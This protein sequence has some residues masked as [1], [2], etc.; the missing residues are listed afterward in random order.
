MNFLNEL[1]SLS[2]SLLLALVLS[3]GV[4]FAYAQFGPDPGTVAPN[5]NVPAPVNVGTEAQVKAGPL[6]VTA[7]TADSIQMNGQTLRLSGGTEG[8]SNVGYG[9]ATVRGS[10]Q[11]WGGF[12]FKSIDGSADYGTLMMH[13]NYSGFYLPGNA[14]WRWYVDNAGNS[15]QSG[16]VSAGSVSASTVNASTVNTSIV[17]APGYVYSPTYYGYPNIGYHLVPNGTSRLNTINVDY[18]CHPSAGCSEGY[19]GYTFYLPGW[20]ASYGYGDYRMFGQGVLKNGYQFSGMVWCD[21]NDHSNGRWT[22]CGYGSTLDC[23]M[24]PYLTEPWGRWMLRSQEECAIA[25]GGFYT[26]YSISV[27]NLSVSSPSRVW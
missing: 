18:Y 15:I 21:P 14:G 19:G 2:K 8:A 1:R 13:Q 17:N 6:G 27:R 11:G 12:N 22:S 10:K 4:S 24:W 3:L 20:G 16:S 9:A 23:T 25:H 26:R 7:F 5:N